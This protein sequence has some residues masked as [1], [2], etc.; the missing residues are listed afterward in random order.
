MLG[1]ETFVR[2]FNPGMVMHFG[3]DGISV[4]T[5]LTMAPQ[6]WLAG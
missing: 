4:E 3:G 6:Q 2:V 5:F 1:M